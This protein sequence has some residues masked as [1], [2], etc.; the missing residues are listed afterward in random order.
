[1]ATIF[2]VDDN[3][4]ISR[5]LGLLMNLIGHQTTC[6]TDP[7]DLLPALRA[8]RPAVVLLDL[9]M[10][11]VDG[12]SVL[13]LVRNDPDRALAATPILIWSAVC[14]H[15][16]MARA[17]AAG[18][19]DYLIKGIPFDDLLERLIPFVGDAGRSRSK[20]MPLDARTMLREPP[21]DLLPV[22]V[23]LDLAPPRRTRAKPAAPRPAHL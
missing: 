16:C 12:F 19:N 17:A 3:S 10:P 21:D 9:S 15:D 22:A 7:A 6:F 13:R 18:A 23:A 1:L 5:P 11:G 8:R 2:I 20:Q 4:M 14:D